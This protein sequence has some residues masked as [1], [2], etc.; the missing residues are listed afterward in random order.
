MCV[1][2]QKLNY[3]KMLYYLLVVTTMCSKFRSFVKKADYHPGED[4][5]GVG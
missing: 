3:N 2:E 1:V 5:V 4:L